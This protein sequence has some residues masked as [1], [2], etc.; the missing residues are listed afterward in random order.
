[1][2]LLL[3]ASGAVTAI[4]AIG[5]FSLLQGG[6][7]MGIMALVFALVYVGF[8][9]LCANW[10]RGV[11]PVAAA[12]AILMAIYAGVAA[13]SWFGRDRAGFEEAILPSSLLGVLTVIL[14]PLQI[15]ITIV[16]II[17]FNQDWHVEEERPI[18]PGTDYG[19]GAE[20][21]YGAGA[22]PAA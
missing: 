17:A 14:I 3:L 22:Q 6:A 4:V 5:G 1:M 11:L 13:P 10:S 20:G 7:A 18:G 21:N 2:V 15:A 9:I 16:A 12:A 8:A 19:V